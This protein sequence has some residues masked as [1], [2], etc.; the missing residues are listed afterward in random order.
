MEFLQG[1]AHSIEAM[2]GG[3]A[4]SSITHLIAIASGLIGLILSIMKA[5]TY[6]RDKVLKKVKLFMISEESFWDRPPKRSLA[7]HM[8]Q[9]REGTPVLTIEN[10]KGGV[11]K[12]TIAANLAAHYDHCGLKVLLIDFDYQGSLTDAVV[13]T[14]GNLKLGAVDLIE[15]KKTPEELLARREKPIEDYKHT[16][17]F[18][19][20]YTLSRVENRV[21]FRWLGGESNGDVRYNLHKVLTSQEMRAQN[22]DIIIIDAPP[23]LMTASV[24]ALC[25]STHVLVPTILDNMSTSAAVNTL[26]AILKMKQKIS[27]GLKVLGVI[28][29][30][31]SQSTYR[32]RELEALQ[33]LCF[34]I[35]SRF[36]R[37]QDSEIAIFRDERIL[38]REAFAK[39]EA[40]QVAYFEN[41]EVR[42]MF[43]KLGDKIATCIGGDFARKLS[44][45]S[46]RLEAEIEVVRSATA[47]VGR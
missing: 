12:S 45:A 26:D 41:A 44:D 37:M 1:L 18:A 21:A 7:N 34:E 35:E 14:N 10:F 28:P 11:G 23:R 36:S 20:A 42:D 31:V 17:I 5:Y 8:R 15:N 16:D 29:T 13:K 19:S 27:P 47:R 25:A 33:Y 32:S 22:Y 39:V 46:D 38:R 40:H 6:G 3:I 30:F 2:A 4:N 9:L 43:A 24:N